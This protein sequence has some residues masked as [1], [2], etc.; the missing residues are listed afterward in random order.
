[1][2]GTL[3][4]FGLMAWIVLCFGAAAFGT[5][6]TDPSWYGVLQKPSWAPPAWLFGPVW[7]LLYLTM[8]IAAWLVWRR[9]GFSGASRALSLFLVQLALNAAWTWIFF[10]MR[11]P[12]WALVEIVVLW[13]LIF[14]TVLAFRRHSHAASWLLVPYLAWVNFAAVLNASL[15]RLNQ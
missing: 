13:V 6:T 5:L 12:G 15:W 14:A 11:R 2:S 9:D 1:M 8:G 4:W 7:S 3:R 10:G